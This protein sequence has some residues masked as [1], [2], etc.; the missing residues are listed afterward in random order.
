MMSSSTHSNWHVRPGQHDEGQ[1]TEAIEHYTSMA[2]SGMYLSIALACIG[3]SAFLHLSGRKQDAQFV[4]QW[5][6]PFLIM[7]L[8]NKVVK[9]QGSD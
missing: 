3:A 2:P 7:G 9:V 1:L 4:G 6:S 8:Y 5:V